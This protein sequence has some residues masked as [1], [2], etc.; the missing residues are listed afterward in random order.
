[1]KCYFDFFFFLNS[2]SISQPDRN[3]EDQFEG[4][5]QAEEILSIEVR[6]SISH[7][8]LVS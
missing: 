4:K 6:A 7:H 5:E 3:Q 8:S 1:M 2:L